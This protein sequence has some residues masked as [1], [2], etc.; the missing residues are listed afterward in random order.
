MN[1]QETKLYLSFFTFDFVGSA[2]SFVFFFHP[3]H[4]GQT[5]SDFEEC[6]KK[7]TW[8]AQWD[9]NQSIFSWILIK[10]GAHY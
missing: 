1:E 6:V 4:N 9:K 7:K 10:N 3:S 8:F 5:T 2:C